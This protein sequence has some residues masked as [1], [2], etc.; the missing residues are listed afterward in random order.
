MVK[1]ATVV[2]AGLVL[3]AGFR[4]SAWLLDAATGAWFRWQDKQ[5]ADDRHDVW[6]TSLEICSMSSPREPQADDQV[7]VSF[8]AEL[9]NPAGGGRL[10]RVKVVKDGHECLVSLPDNATVEPLRPRV[11]LP[12]G[13][14][15][16]GDVVALV[17]VSDRERRIWKYLVRVGP[18]AWQWQTGL[19]GG[20]SGGAVGTWLETAR[21]ATALQEVPR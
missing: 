9:H 11:F 2:S 14:E 4:A 8:T 12:D 16:P 19:T 7:V 17:D 20:P 3:L 1:P 13:P 18:V 6:P 5:T 10:A 21:F 15:P